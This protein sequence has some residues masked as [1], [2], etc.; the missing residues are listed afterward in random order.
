[1]EDSMKK[2]IILAACLV[3]FS[4]FN[5][6]ICC[7]T[8][9]PIWNDKLPAECNMSLNLY[10]TYYKA[11]DKSGTVTMS[12]ACIHKLRRLECQEL[13][14]GKDE[15]GKILFDIE[16]KNKLTEYYRCLSEK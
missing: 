7:N 5:L 2:Y 15:N 11:D 14:F 12:T 8:F 1:M 3:I 10:R 9:K 6:F 4:G 13:I 16:D